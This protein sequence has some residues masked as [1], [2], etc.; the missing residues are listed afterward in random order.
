MR[1]NREPINDYTGMLGRYEK[2]DDVFRGQHPDTRSDKE[3]IRLMKERG[4]ERPKTKLG[5]QL[6]KQVRCIN[7]GMEFK[8]IGEAESFYGLS[9]GCIVRHI[10]LKKP[11]KFFNMR[12]LKFEFID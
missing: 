9:R 7:T 8:S 1:I 6:M 2:I 5:M 3:F 4:L 11:F 12:D 10:K